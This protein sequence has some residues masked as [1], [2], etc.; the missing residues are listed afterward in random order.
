[1]PDPAADRDIR[2][3]LAAFEWLLE[4]A[5]L[6]DG[7]RPWTVLSNGFEFEWAWVP[8]VRR[9]RW[10]SQQVFATHLLITTEHV[11]GDPAL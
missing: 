6:Y 2:I 8:L 3:R 11:S 7:V 5:D 1:M 10:L 4:Q 9:R